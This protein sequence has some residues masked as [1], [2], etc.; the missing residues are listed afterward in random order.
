M[1]NVSYLGNKQI[2]LQDIIK[3]KYNVKTE[4]VWGFGFEGFK[5]EHNFP[6]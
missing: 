1:P 6:H 3:L 4:G 5:N 2:P